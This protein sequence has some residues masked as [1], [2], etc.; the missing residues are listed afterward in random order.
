[1]KLGMGDIII[2]IKSPHHGSLKLLSSDLHT[3]SGGFMGIHVQ[4]L[5]FWC[6]QFL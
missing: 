6:T 2:E 5:K 1:M 4:W 3:I